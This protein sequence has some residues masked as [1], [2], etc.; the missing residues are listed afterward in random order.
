VWGLPAPGGKWLNWSQG[1]ASARALEF[2]TANSQFPL[3]G[4]LISYFNTRL[5]HSVESSSNSNGQSDCRV[6]C[7]FSSRAEHSMKHG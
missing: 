3:H 7:H 6:Y 2:G 4:R 1:E 5:G